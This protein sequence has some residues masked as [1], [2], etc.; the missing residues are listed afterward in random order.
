VNEGELTGQVRTHIAEVADPNCLLHAQTVRPFLNLRRA[1]LEEGIDLKPM[2]GF[3]DFERQLAIWNSKWRGAR[4]LYDAA[5]GKL[6]AAELAPE[7][8][9][10]AILLWS[11]L[12]GA[13]RHHWGTDV[14]LVDGNASAE[15]YPDKLTRAAFAPGAPFA[16][17]D[18]WLEI[19]APRFGFFRP[20]RGVRSG[21]QAEPWHLSF[22]PIAEI[23]RRA[24]SP[25]VLQ[26]AIMAA[27]LL[28]KELVLARLEELHA[29][30]VAAIDLP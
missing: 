7:E 24:L 14:D 4:P 21:V 18:E 2:S 6:D 13:S 11:A 12:P 10:E 23:A 16:R 20:F 1:A 19:N 26:A 15:G 28:G 5:G 30:Y 25:T 8:R 22:A 9:V 29:R 3:R 27:P 17:L